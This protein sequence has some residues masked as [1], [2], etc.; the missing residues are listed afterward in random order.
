[1]I[2]TGK[3]IPLP[4]ASD[5]NRCLAHGHQNGE[6]CERRNTCACHETIKHDAGIKAPAAFRKCISDKF[7]AYLP[8]DGF[9]IDDNEEEGRPA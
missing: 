4:L 5:I 8:L 9:P 1:M 6:W 7:A 3:P 2:F